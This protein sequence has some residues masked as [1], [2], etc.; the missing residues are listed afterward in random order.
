MH[1]LARIMNGSMAAAQNL[2][3]A[4]L[5]RKA[6]LKLLPGLSPVTLPFGVVLYETP[7][8]SGT[9]R[10]RAMAASPAPS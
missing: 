4:S 3:L 6:Y 9:R 7:F 10:Y 5:P 2:I 1:L 8:H